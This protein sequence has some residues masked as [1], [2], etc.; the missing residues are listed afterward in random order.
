MRQPIAQMGSETVGVHRQVAFDERRQPAVVQVVAD[1]K[2]GGITHRG[3]AAQRCLDFPELDAESAD[4][5][6]L[7]APAEELHS[8]V[9][10]RAHKIA[11]AEHIAAAFWVERMGIKRSAVRGWL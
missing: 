2:N 9:G 7:V 10:S 4:F 1:G 6:L 11:G 8:A 3:M 5:H